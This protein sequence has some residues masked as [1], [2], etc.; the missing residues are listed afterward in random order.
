MRNLNNP[1]EIRLSWEKVPDAT[2]YLLSIKKKNEKKALLQTVVND[3]A[4]YT[5]DFKILSDK[6]KSA[7]SKGNFAWSV[8]PVR[9][10]DSDKDGIPD[11]LLQ[12]GKEAKSSF[13]TDIPIPKKSK[14]KGASNPYGN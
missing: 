3:K 1:K 9:R 6:D 10:I 2:E 12:E 8:K 4:S 13:M 14:A 11:K 7:F 5:L